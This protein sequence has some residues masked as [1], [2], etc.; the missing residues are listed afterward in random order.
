MFFS[1]VTTALNHFGST[2]CLV[3]DNGEVLWVP[4]AQFT[5]L[6]QLNLRYWPFDT[7]ECY[8][9]FGSWTYNGDQIDLTI[10]NNATEVE[11]TTLTIKLFYTI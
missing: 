6:C 10:M 3:Y 8:M 1:A 9:K 5:V 2:H 7:Q 11:V 4:P